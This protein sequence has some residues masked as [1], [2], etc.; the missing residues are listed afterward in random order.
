MITAK[1]FRQLQ[2][3]EDDLRRAFKAH[4]KLA[5][6]TSENMLIEEILRKYEPKEQFNWGCGNCA[7]RVYTRMGAKYFEYKEY[8]E[9]KKK[10]LEA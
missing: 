8:V 5:T 9:S 7:L 2:P 1:E 3:Y 6:P 10:S 4:Y